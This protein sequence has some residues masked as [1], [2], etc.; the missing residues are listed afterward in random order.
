[1]RMTGFVVAALILLPAAMPGGDNAP[2]PTL[3]D[4]WKALQASAWVNEKAEVAWAKLPESF[5]KSYSEKGW[6]KVDVKFYEAPGKAGPGGTKARVDIAFTAAG[7][8]KA[9][10]TWGNL[11][12]TLQEDKDARYFVLK[13]HADVEYKIQYSLKDGKLALKGTF[14]SLNPDI[15]TP[16]IFDGEYSP[17]AVKKK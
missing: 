3:A 2:S 13:G 5:K 7:Q 15:G 16:T 6:K 11:K 10:P 14:F 12:L 9:Y 8:E 1:M 4:D 17:V